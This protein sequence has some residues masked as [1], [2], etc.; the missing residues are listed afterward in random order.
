MTEGLV[1]TG[2]P[3][4]EDSDSPGFG[5]ERLEPLLLFQSLLGNAY[6]FR[7]FQKGD[8]TLDLFLQEGIFSVLIRFPD[9]NRPAVLTFVQP[10]K[11]QIVVGIG[12]PRLLLQC[13]FKLLD[14][15]I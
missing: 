2:I 1:R 15:L 7:D 10:R 14:G 4:I 9:F 6:A 3:K 8:V 5:G 11:S 13:S 12:I